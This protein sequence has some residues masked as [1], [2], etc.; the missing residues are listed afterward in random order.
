[1]VP[2]TK[3]AQVGIWWLEACP[4]KVNM[5]LIGKEIEKAEKRLGIWLK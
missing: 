3:E 4:R 2:D 1:V 5:R